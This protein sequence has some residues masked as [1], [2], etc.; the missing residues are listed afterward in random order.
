[1]YTM[2]VLF[3][4]VT[5]AL[6]ALG[7]A[8][9]ELRLSR[10]RLAEAEARVVAEAGVRHAVRVIHDRGVVR[11]DTDVVQAWPG[12]FGTS[13]IAVVG[14]PSLTYA[15]TPSSDAADPAR[16]ALL[17][18]VGKASDG[19]RRTVRVQLSLDGVFSPGAIYLPSG[20]LRTNFSGNSFSID[21]RNTNLDGTLR[22]GVEVPGIGT[23][24]TA[25]TDSV[26]GSLSSQQRGNVLGVGGAPSVATS[27]GPTT[28]AITNHIVP[29]ILARPGVVTNPKLGGNDVFGT[30]S[31]PQTT[32]FTG[33]V[34]IDGNLQGAGI[35]IVDRGL[36]I[37]GSMTFTGLVI[38]RGSTDITSVQGNARVL[39]ALWAIDPVLNVSG[40][41]SV[42]YSTAALELAN[43]TP[44]G[45]VLPQRVTAT[46]W[47]ES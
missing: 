30:A 19:S 45:N 42:S 34:R 31:Q 16:V 17:T 33:S 4:T 29:S 24:A 26:L 8:G 1:L 21:G 23:A 11:F 44:S 9:S 10:M 25:A 27:T 41:A 28:D 43:V 7:I 39:G 47:A 22:P 40:N 36:T 37:S 32:Y 20:P 14:H 35:L 3:A 18:A 12:L 15:V 6:S 2:T 5:L 38:V 46:G 13:P